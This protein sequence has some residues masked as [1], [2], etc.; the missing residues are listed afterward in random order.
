MQRSAGPS[1][2]LPAVVV[3]HPEVVTERQNHAKLL[4]CWGT[5]VLHRH[6]FLVVL[7][8]DIPRS[9]VTFFFFIQEKIVKTACYQID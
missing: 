6:S 2:L 5:E 8:S 9:C 4:D 7:F 1:S 3:P